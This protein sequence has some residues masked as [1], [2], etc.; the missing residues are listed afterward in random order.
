MSSSGR[1]KERLMQVI[2]HEHIQ[3][4]HRWFPRFSW[5][6]TTKKG[7][8]IYF[9]VPLQKGAK[10]PSSRKLWLVYTMGAK[11]CLAVCFRNLVT[12]HLSLELYAMGPDA[13]LNHRLKWSAAQIVFIKSIIG[14]KARSLK[15]QLSSP[16]IIIGM[17]TGGLV[18]SFLTRHTSCR[19]HT[20]Y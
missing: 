6:S 16:I 1:G 15:Q 11:C 20:F 3:G 18:V 9:A 13:D 10:D 19:S 8:G 12:R 2:E 7:Q 5:M 4:G 14:G 17:R